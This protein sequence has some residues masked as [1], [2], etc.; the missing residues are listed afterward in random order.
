M[1]IAISLAREKE[2]NINSNLKR[3]KIRSDQAVVIKKIPMNTPKDMIIAIEPKF[4]KIK[5]IKI[6][7]IRMWQKTVVEFGSSSPSLDVSSLGST[8]SPTS[9]NTSGLS[10]CL[11]VLEYS[12]KLLSDQVSVLLKKLSFVELVP[13]TTFFSVLSSVALASLASVLDLNMILDNVLVS[14]I[15]SFFAGFDILA[16]FSSSSFKILTTKVGGLESKMVALEISINSVLERLDHLCSGLGSLDKVHS[17]IANKFDGVYVFISGVD[18]D[19]LGSGVAIIM[20]ISLVH[21]MYRIS[22]VPVSHN[23]MDV[24][25]HFDT[26]HKAVSVSVNL[27]RL[28]N[29]WLNSI[30]K[31]ANRDCW[32][33]DFK[34]ADEL[35]W[36]EFMGAI[37]ANAAMFSSEFDASNLQN[38]RGLKKQ[39][40]DMSLIGE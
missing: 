22:E 12:L 16:N 40:L 18:S 39:A 11:T 8:L 7:L 25:K 13:L 32:K 36:C 15:S 4:G 26:N 17:W 33:F 2:I 27:S 23:V 35:K 19:Y 5:S 34:N 1:E 3:Q 14:F 10:N 31:Q 20:N 38:L 21:H 30:H 24:S 37:V 9:A 29:V 6:Q 28:L